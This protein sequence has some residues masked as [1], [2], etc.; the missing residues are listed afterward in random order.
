MTRPQPAFAHVRPDRLRAVE[1]ARQVDPEVPL[2]QLRRLLLELCRVVERPGIVHEDV[3]RA[4]FPDGAGN[5]HIDL[6]TFRDVAADGD[7]TT[8]HAA[9]LLDG[10]LG[11]HETLRARNGRER[12]VAVGVLRQL[13][14]DEQVGND[15]IRAGSGERQR[16][17]PSKSSRSSGDECHSAGEIDLNRHAARIF[18]LRSRAAGSGWS[19]HKS[20]TASRRA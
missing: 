13:R 2:P 14:F 8:A 11:V 4:E 18:P 19:P 1:G 15:D 6:R 7:R 9:Y 10:L 5:R 16:V 12:A 20:E 17:R 3:D